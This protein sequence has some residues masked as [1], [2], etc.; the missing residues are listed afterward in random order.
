MELNQPSTMLK[1]ACHFVPQ[2]VLYVVFATMNHVTQGFS[3]RN[4]VDRNEWFILY[5]S[6]CGT[7]GGKHWDSSSRNQVIVLFISRLN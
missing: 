3:H 2:V 7:E 6:G 1:K 5:M 4:N